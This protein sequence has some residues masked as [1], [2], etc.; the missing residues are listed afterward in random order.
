IEINSCMYEI[1]EMLGE[2]G[3][4]AV[5]A[6]T[7][8]HDGLE[9]AVKYAKKS[10]H[11]DYISIP[12]HPEPLPREVALHM[13]ACEG[14]IVPEIIRLLDWQ[15]YQN[16]YIMVLERPS[17]CEDLSEFIASKGAELE[18]ELARVIMRQA[19]TAA[20]MSCE[21]GV[22]HR[23]IKLENLLIRTDTMNV[24]LIDFGCGDLLKKSTY[25]SYTGTINYVCPEYFETGEYRGKPSTVYSLGVLLFAM[26]CR[27]F[28]SD[29]DLHLINEK[30]WSK[31]GLT[32]ECCGLLQACLQQ[33]PDER[34]HLENIR[35]HAWF[36]ESDMSNLSL[37]YL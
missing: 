34:I 3:F 6:G 2:G 21:R 7:R 20:Y 23:D 33:N 15:D 35:D 31:D 11:L 26:L 12:G 37:T 22:F 4:G 9:V 36:E 18:E 27:R 13:L 32:E 5:F 28:P 17:P 29:F 19:T 25:K 10:K 16:R 30:T 14:E 24:K 1:G 8:V